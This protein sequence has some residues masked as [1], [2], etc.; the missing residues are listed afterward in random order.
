MLRQPC[1]HAPG[2]CM[3]RWP[4]PQKHGDSKV[5]RRWY[6]AVART[7]TCKVAIQSL[8]ETSSLW[9]LEVLLRTY[10][11]SLSSYAP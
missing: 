1:G 7:D 2:R 8:E 3:M 5:F 4:V 9:E 11:A 10:A 6:L